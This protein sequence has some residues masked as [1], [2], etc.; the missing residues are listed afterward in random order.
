MRSKRDQSRSGF[1]AT[2]RYRDAAAAI[3]WLCAAF[4][5]EKQQVVTHAD[6]S[7]RYATMAYGG[8][9]IILLPADGLNAATPT[10][11]S[12]VD[13]CPSI[14]SCYC[15]VNDAEA[16][17]RN[18][19][20]QGAVIVE[21]LGDY[22]FVGSGYS[23]K[24]PEGH[25]WNFGTHDP[26]QLKINIPVPSSGAMLR[27]RLARLTFVVVGIA[28]VTAWWAFSTG[29]GSS[30]SARV[31][32]DNGIE[33]ITRVESRTSEP[34]PL[35]DVAGAHL[36]HPSHAAPPREESSTNAPDPRAQSAERAAA[37]T[38]VPLQIEAAERALKDPSVSEAEQSTVKPPPTPVADKR[39]EHVGEEVRQQT[40][41]APSSSPFGSPATDNTVAASLAPPMERAERPS[42]DPS[43]RE[44]FEIAGKPP[45]DAMMPQHDGGS[46]RVQQEAAAPPSLA[47]DAGSPAKDKSRRPEE[48][49]GV[50]VRAWTC[51]PQSP[52]GQ[53]ICRPLIP[54]TRH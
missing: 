37:V 39:D 20:A 24:D 6:G 29:E 34:E 45:D 50:E 11:G 32:K 33:E 44:V 13:T 27:Y 48:V 7:V 31:F 47:T 8:D 14:Q 19:K 35:R 43:G 42:K 36:D 18:A 38:N 15:I 21:D 46:K 49:R 28:L 2:L 17:Y 25:I 5:F 30:S 16:H 22:D 23:C 51:R 10:R 4:G 54:R 9:T 52:T 3:E 12:G 41:E 26:R 53:V 40:V 1:V